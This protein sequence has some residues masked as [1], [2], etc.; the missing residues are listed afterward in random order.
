M[1]NQYAGD[2]HDYRK[3]TLL[4]LMASHYKKIR[5]VWLLTENDN[6]NHGENREYLKDERNYK[7]FDEKLYECLKEKFLAE[8]GK[9]LPKNDRSVKQLE[10]ILNK[11]NEGKFIFCKNLE[12]NM[13][14]DSAD[15]IFFDPNTG[16]GK[17]DKDHITYH[18][19]EKYKNN[20]LLIVHFP[21]FNPSDRDVENQVMRIRKILEKEILPIKAGNTVYF[22]ASCKKNI[23][24]ITKSIGNKYEKFLEI[25]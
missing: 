10:E 11:L 9:F 6:R 24:S 25:P 2:L 3:L 19:I 18:E 23:E 4:R 20:D 14:F 15:L 21:S 8:K 22:Y 1:R 12:E 13:S 5:V 17:K 16:I 7:N